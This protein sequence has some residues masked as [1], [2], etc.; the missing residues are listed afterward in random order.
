MNYEL[1]V[2]E[3]NKKSSKY[4]YQVVD[5]NGNVVSERNSNREYVASTI[6][7]AFLFGRLDLIGK[8]DHGRFLKD[9]QN[10]PDYHKA[11]FVEGVTKIAYRK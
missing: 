8:G 3:S 7:C 10:N 5:E 11:D 4:C 6:N 9:F 1:K 2:T